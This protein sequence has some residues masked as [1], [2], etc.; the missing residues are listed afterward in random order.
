MDF[1]HRC[2]SGKSQRPAP[3]I[4]A[5]DS[6]TAIV[7]PWGASSAEAKK[8]IASFKEFYTD[9]SLNLDH[10]R[11]FPLMSCLS[12]EENNMRTAF[13]HINSL[14]FNKK[15]KEELTGGFEA[16]FVVQTPSQILFVQAG[17]PQIYLSRKGA[18]LEKIGSSLLN[19]QKD[20]LPQELLGLFQDSSFAIHSFQH[21]AGDQLFFISKDFIPQDLAPTG[22]F[23]E[24]AEQLSK[25][26]TPFWL[27]L[28]LL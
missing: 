6:I 27:G 15:N 26:Q 20:P 23:D 5:D 17:C 24:L 13:T 1:H 3:V 21:S 16:A 28:A 11:P 2:F 10:T 25:D 22:S 18:P 19:H 8:V 7:T 9:L 14:W 4:E 12:T